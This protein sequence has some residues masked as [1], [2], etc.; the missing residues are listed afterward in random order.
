MNIILPSVELDIKHIQEKLWA[1]L[2]IPK[3]ILIDSEPRQ[4]SGA[5]V[6][7]QR[8]E[9]SLHEFQ[10]AMI[11]NFSKHVH[12]SFRFNPNPADPI[13]TVD[14]DPEGSRIQNKGW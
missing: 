5:A 14:P 11:F 2:K 12:T 4:Y 9:V 6:G 8:A 13:A 7:L 3:E 10:K 1:S